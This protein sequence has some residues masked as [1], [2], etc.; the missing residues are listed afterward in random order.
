ML[1][2][3]IAYASLFFAPFISGIL[4]IIFMLPLSVLQFLGINKI[5]ISY[6]SSFIGGVTLIFLYSLFFS[7]LK[8]DYGIIAFIIVLIPI[9]YNNIQ[10]VRTR[11]SKDFEKKIGLFEVAGLVL[12]SCI[13]IFNFIQL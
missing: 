11:P 6:I 4:L 2:K 9:I 1:L 3:I 5:Y 10:R 12:G 13:W 7:W 8:I